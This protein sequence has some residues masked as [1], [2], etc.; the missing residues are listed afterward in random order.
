MQ[1]LYFSDIKD[2]PEHSRIREAMITFARNPNPGYEFDMKTRDV[3]YLPDDRFL[4][5]LISVRHYDVA[6]FCDGEM[7][8]GYFGFKK[9][10]DGRVDVC[11][12]YADEK[13]R[14]RKVGRELMMRFIEE[15]RKRGVRRILTTKG[16]KEPLPG[17]KREN[18]AA[19]AG[20]LY[21][22]KEDFNEQ[23]VG[24]RVNPYRGL[25]EILNRKA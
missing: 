16:R 18:D 7:P 21:W 15:C 1:V 4:D 3:R 2:N 14:G 17:T 10:G 6:I 20:V 5:F 13:S 11:F 23:R 12:V 24:V 9:K 19:V 25:I 22:I 8:V